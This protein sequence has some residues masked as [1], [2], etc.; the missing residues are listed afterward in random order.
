M[1]K[2]SL[3]YFVNI[4]TDR[5]KNVVKWGSLSSMSFNKFLMGVGSGPG[6]RGYIMTALP[7]IH[8]G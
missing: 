2:G 1:F 4:G 8:Y 7:G 3:N 6:S 5:F